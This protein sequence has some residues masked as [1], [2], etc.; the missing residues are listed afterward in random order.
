MIS[1]K[2]NSGEELG[3]QYRGGLGRVVITN[4]TGFDAVAKLVD[5]S[6][7]TPRRAI[8]IRQRESGSITSIPPGRYRLQF[9]L[10]TD[11]LTERRFCRLSGSSEFEDTF[12]YAE[13]KS[14]EGIKYSNHEVTLH[15]VKEGKA[16]VRE[17]ENSRFILPPP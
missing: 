9:Q 11:W 6:S 15:P 12:D 14:D 5:N 7:E 2:C 1:I 13:V 8:Y 10:G 17:L 16:K 4:G 3:G